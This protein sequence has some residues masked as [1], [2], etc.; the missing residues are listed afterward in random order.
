MVLDGLFVWLLSDGPRRRDWAVH[1]R[2]RTH[3]AS[4]WCCLWAGSSAWPLTIAPAHGLSMWLGL[5]IEWRWVPRE[6]IPKVSIQETKSGNCQVTYG[7]HLSRYGLL[8]LG[9]DGQSV[10]GTIR[11]QE[12]GWKMNFASERV[13]RSHCRRAF[14]MVGPSVPFETQSSV[15][16]RTHSL[17]LP[18][19]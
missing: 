13:T 3:P 4:S 10:T 19:H 5:L 1:P 9:F 15:P 11:I 7:L 14:G 6:S 18:S 12:G 8:L 16:S 17:H 2:W